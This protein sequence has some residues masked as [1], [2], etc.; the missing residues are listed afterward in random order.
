[1]LGPGV[2]AWG[3]LLPS[4]LVG[5]N[6]G[7]SSKSTEGEESRV[8]DS[9]LSEAG[10]EELE[11]S[12]PGLGA[13]LPK[14]PA[15]RGLS[16]RILYLVILLVATSS[17]SGWSLLTQQRDLLAQLRLLT[18]VYVP[19][20]QRLARARESDLQLRKY[21][22][23]QLENSDA[24]KVGVSSDLLLRVATENR[25]RLV[26]DLRDPLAQ[27]FAQPMRFSPSQLTP[28]RVLLQELSRLESLVED[29]ERSLSQAAGAEVS[30]ETVSR[31]NRIDGIFRALDNQAVAAL[32]AHD[33]AVR[34]AGIR[35]ERHTW[36]V[37]LASLILGALTALAA[38]WTLRPLRKL[39][40]RVR[41]LAAG[42]WGQRISVDSSPVRDNEVTRLGREFDRMASALQERE[43]RLIHSERMAAIG[44]MA[45]QI[46]HEIRNPLSSVALN[47]ELLEDELEEA[48]AGP[49]TRDLFSR[50]NAEVDR[51]T[52]ITES[53]LS[54]TRHRAPV[55]Q[56]LD[57]AV[58]L[59]DLLDFLQNEQAQLNIRV[60]RE[61]G[62]EGLCWVRGDPRQLRQA[63]LNLLRN[64]QEAVL[65]WEARGEPKAE[66]WVAE[67]SVEIHRMAGPQPEIEVVIADNGPGIA[68]SPTQRARIFEPFVTHKAQGTGLGLPMVQQIMLAHGGS[69]AVLTTGPKGTRF[70]LTFPAC[71][72]Q[73]SSVSSPNF[74]IEERPNSDAAALLPAEE[75]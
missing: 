23:Q 1:M 7:F 21:R 44:Q 14:I 61:L 46:T 36:F 43:R 17:A 67:I 6:M 45:A 59:R 25:G 58:Q 55:F 27:A 4:A 50:V 3:G 63:F 70:G 34:L 15:F 75:R 73:S 72:G 8:D 69:V 2:Q 37:T 39:T 51:L 19:F 11:L 47:V 41:R 29:D 16:A 60:R 48:G 22:L 71:Q 13:P 24:R 30:N 68:G 56:R 40:E 20:Q 54:F 49:D 42:D 9:I 10:A 74:E 33:D 65:E 66:P 35:A 26:R 18:G 31:I 38:S 64:A 53:Y 62:A 52:Q 32:R 28:V 12:R 5:P 57:L